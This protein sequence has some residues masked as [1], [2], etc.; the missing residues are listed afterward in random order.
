MCAI[1][2]GVGAVE[3]EKSK[4]QR[5]R[6]ASAEDDHGSRLFAKEAVV[7]A[8]PGASA[9]RAQSC[10]RGRLAAPVAARL[11]GEGVVALAELKPP[12]FCR[13][14]AVMF[15]GSEGFPYHPRQRKRRPDLRRTGGA[16]L[17]AKA[18]PLV[19]RRLYAILQRCLL[20]EAFDEKD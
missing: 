13:I 7:Q 3:G 6:A 5:R 11:K 18:P 14:N 10:C 16:F 15:F 9:A 1:E 12:C 8:F 20:L 19:P 2:A 4:V 17:L